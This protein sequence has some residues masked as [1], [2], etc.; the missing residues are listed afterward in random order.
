M[1]NYNIS[2]DQ[3][4]GQVLYVALFSY[5][6]RGVWEARKYTLKGTDIEGPSWVSTPSWASILQ[7]GVYKSNTIILRLGK[8]N[9]V[10]FFLLRWYKFCVKPHRMRTSCPAERGVLPCHTTCYLRSPTRSR[11][12]VG[13]SRA[14]LSHHPSIHTEG[15]A[16]GWSTL[17]RISPPPPSPYPG[18]NSGNCSFTPFCR[19]PHTK[20][21]GRVQQAGK[22]PLCATA[23][24]ASPMRP[25]CRPAWSK[26]G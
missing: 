17:Y 24:P 20:G 25:L 16:A 9:K 21:R 12:G 23:S 2:T 15:A 26:I 7:N 19:L 22:E 11:G 6:Q 4:L 14:D 5:Q 13:N 3:F 18:V 1:M 10:V 8:M